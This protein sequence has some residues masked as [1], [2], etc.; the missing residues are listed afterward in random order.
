V[1]I[2]TLSGIVVFDAAISF[3]LALNNKLVMKKI[4]L[5]HEHFPPLFVAYT[6]K[7]A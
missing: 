4:L 2:L 6:N 1:K 5:F 3:L 7:R